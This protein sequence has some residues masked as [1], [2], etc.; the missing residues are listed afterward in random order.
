MKT[1]IF[2][3][4]AGILTQLVFLIAAAMLLINIVFLNLYEK[5]LIKAKEQAGGLLALSV[6]NN[7][8]F[9]LDDG[10]A[11]LKDLASYSDFTAAVEAMLMASEFSDLAIVNSSGEAVFRAGFSG[12]KKQY[13]LTSAMNAMS[14]GMTSVSF[15]GTTWGVLWPG[16]SEIFLSAPLK[17]KGRVIGGISITSSLLPVYDSLRKSEKLVI[18]YIVVDTVILALVGIYL[19]SRIVVA[20]IQRLVRMTEEYEDS[21]SIPSAEDTPANEIRNLSRA[22]TN[23]LKRLDENKKELKNHII[24]LEKANEDLKTARDEIIK[25]EKLASVGRLA[26]GIAHEIGNPVGIILG[27]IELIQ[28]GGLSKE[29]END[30]LGRIESEISRVDVI[31][32]QLLDFSRSS[33]KKLGVCEVHKLITGTVEMLEPQS[34]LNELEI[35]LELE[36]E[37]DQVFADKNQ[38][39]QVFLNILINSIDAFTEGRRESGYSCIKIQSENKNETIE[40]RFIDNGPG[41]SPDKLNRIFDP[42]FTTKEPGRGTGLGLSVCYRIIESLGGTIKAESSPGNGMRLYVEL[43]LYDGTCYLPEGDSE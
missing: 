43:P 15:T 2:G 5:D 21:E 32:R 4:R 40:L 34:R 36:A 24:S 10:V 38:L 19:L 35:G 14:A 8:G 11:D 28:K 3:L 27:Y 26:A 39:Q 1:K 33:T 17:Y 37:N 41:I 18:L 12:E 31:I 13:I 23:M 30:F 20:P 42:F 9:I 6:E 22:L 7:M 29:D 16:K 25:S